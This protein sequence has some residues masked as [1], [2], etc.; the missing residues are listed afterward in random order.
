VTAFEI[1]GWALVHSLW[2]DVLVAASLATLLAIIPQQAA[3]TR[4]ALATA[5]LFILIAL[6]VAT[7]LR[8]I[9]AVDA[10][11]WLTVHIGGRIE[12]TLPWLASLWLAGVAITAARLGYRWQS[13]RHMALAE[14][15]EVPTR[16]REA[17]ARLAGRLRVG[18]PVRLVASTL[19]HAPALV[20]WL[21]PVILLPVS[22]VMGGGLTPLQLDAL[23][24]H[25]LAH[26][27]RHDY[28]VN[29]LQSLIETLLFYHPA[30]WWVSARVR[31][32]REQCCDDMAVAACGDAHTYA[33]ALVAMDQLRTSRALVLAANGGSLL[34]RISRLVRPDLAVPSRRR[35]MTWVAMLALTATAFLGEQWGRAVVSSRDL[36]TL[37]TDARH[38][39][40]RHD[41][42]KQLGRTR[43]PRAMRVLL[44]V[45][46]RDPNS[47]VRHEAVQSLGTAFPDTATVRVLAR[48]A[49]DDRDKRVAKEAV[50]TLGEMRDGLGLHE[51]VYIARTHPDPKMR[52][53]AV[54]SIRDEAPRATALSILREIA[55]HDRDANVQRKAERAL[56]KL[57]DL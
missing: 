29:M 4:Y 18:R 27:R 20:G 9:N 13:T 53:E 55:Q 24:A 47:D 12:P 33:S 37:A 50:E 38:A 22:V 6:P 41:A 32:E 11:F 43:D 56:A 17:L 8:P 1:M 15:Q 26:V 25:E 35:W 14:A 34:H 10:V 51:V 3:R 44:A 57:R 19:V 39:R 42:V 31:D 23:L 48:I 30:A 7:A 16:F 45:A 40:V 36:I 2:Q 54:E 49:Q 52:R 5:A 21:R 46:Q 28:L